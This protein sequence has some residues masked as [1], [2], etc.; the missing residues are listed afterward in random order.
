M[1]GSV[2]TFEVYPLHRRTYVSRW[3]SC[4]RGFIKYTHMLKHG[5]IYEKGGD[6]TRKKKT[7]TV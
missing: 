2:E 3:M 4:D 7:L 6:V 5:N 1:Y